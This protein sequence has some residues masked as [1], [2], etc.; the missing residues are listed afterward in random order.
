MKTLFFLVIFL[1]LSSLLSADEV[2]VKIQRVSGNQVAVVKDSSAAGRGMRGGDAG[3]SAPMQSRRGRGRRTETTST[4]PTVITIDRNVKIT[5]AMRE[6]RTFEFRV[7]AELAGG[8]RHRVFQN[9]R[10]P[11][12]ARIVTQ[13]N[14][15]TEVNVLIPET[16]INQSGT[17]VGGQTVMAVRPKRPPTKRRSTTSR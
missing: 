9:M 13:G 4:Q 8:L 14:R 11:L 15:I 1:T 16:D 17:T 7:G 6:R 5:S 12:S 2:F 3:T 10:S